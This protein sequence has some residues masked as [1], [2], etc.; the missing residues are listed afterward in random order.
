M[1]S[2]FGRIGL[3]AWRGGG[4]C[5]SASHDG[6]TPTLIEWAG[7]PPAMARLIDAFYDRV[8]KAYA[9]VQTGEM[10]AWGNFLFKKGVIA[11]PLRP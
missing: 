7:G 6:A 1:T 8:D 3:G 10:Q 5:C 11:E 9:I 2:R 4:G